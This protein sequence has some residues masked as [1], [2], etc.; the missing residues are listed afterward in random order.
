MSVCRHGTNIRLGHR[1][2]SGR[3]VILSEFV[4][5]ELE[6]LATYK[7][8][9]GIVFTGSKNQELLGYNSKM[10]LFCKYV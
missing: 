6:L 2:L 1:C 3:L 4:Y 9:V 7:S 8:K 10:I 5:S